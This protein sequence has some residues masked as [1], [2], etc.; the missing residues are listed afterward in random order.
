MPR[1][2]SDIPAI[3][4][5]MLD[6]AAVRRARRIARTPSQIPT[7]ATR[8]PKTGMPKPIKPQMI[9]PTPA[10]KPGCDTGTEAGGA[11]PLDKDRASA[12]GPFA[13]LDMPEPSPNFSGWVGDRHREKSMHCHRGSK[14]SPKTVGLR[15]RTE[16]N[17]PLST[18]VIASV[19]KQ[20]S[21][22]A[23]KAGLLRYARN[24]ALNFVRFVSGLSPNGRIVFSPPH[25]RPEVACTAHG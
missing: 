20:S 25:A 12:S 21:A 11:M 16:L 14:R 7:Q 10:I 23:P 24:D 17:E 13:S 2:D 15:R 18:P 8:M 19:A 3:P 9:E 6:L 1:T 5:I 4:Q 22:A